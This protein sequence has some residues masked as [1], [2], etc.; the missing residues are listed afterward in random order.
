[1]T[2][3]TRA[4]ILGAALAAFNVA[5]IDR[6][7]IAQVRAAA[8]V[9]NGSF[10]HFFAS[11]EKLASALFLDALDAYHASMVAEIHPRRDA[12][13]GIALLVQTHIEWV[14]SQR[15][16]A[17]FLFE[18]VRS[19]WLTSIREEQAARNRSFAEAIDQWRSPHLRAGRLHPLPLTV[20]VGQLIGPAQVLCRAWLSGRSDEDPRAHARE[21]A[22][23]ACRA[24]VV[25]RAISQK[26]ST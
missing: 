3:T 18:Q 23:C 21:L 14:C 17:I 6:T 15:P 22:E 5:G 7:T 13:E 24:L 9:S 16:Q 11:K 19:E 1:M 12:A 10:F 20:F 4:A 2:S 25:P 26:E 8:G